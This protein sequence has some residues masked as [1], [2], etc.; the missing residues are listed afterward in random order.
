MEWSGV[1]VKTCG[2][3]FENEIFDEV[4]VELKA[5]ACRIKLLESNRA[6]SNCGYPRF[7]SSV[8][9]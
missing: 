5:N 7:G 2:G 1:E 6:E 4:G 9:G 8:R 3:G